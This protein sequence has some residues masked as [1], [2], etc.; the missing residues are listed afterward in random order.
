[1]TAPAVVL[2]PL[3]G[4][5]AQ[6][7]NTLMAVADDLGEGW[8]LIGG[9]MVLL[10]QTERSPAGAQTVGGA[11]LRW[12]YDLDVVVNLRT[13][14]SRMS[15]I[16]S[17]LTG[18]GFTQQVAPIGHRYVDAAGAVF[19]VL[20]PDHLG[21]HLPRLGRGSTLQAPGGTQA[22]KRTARVTVEHNQQ[23]ASIPRPSLVGALLIKIAAASG[24][25]SGRDPDRHLLDVVTLATLVTPQDVTDAGLTRK[26]RRR[27]RRAAQIV[28]Q[29]RDVRAG[30]A[31]AALS[32]LVPAPPS[33]P[34]LGRDAG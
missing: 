24:P 17:V 28:S 31:A 4:Q 25:P 20:A 7:W 30:A 23:Q 22:L 21:R 27:I 8:T 3:E 18:H 9:Q 15:H 29:V 34:G 1:M 19:D 11:G 5:Q 33:D 6:A 16:D 26:E 13:S 2:P 10:H 32:L 12:S 14:R